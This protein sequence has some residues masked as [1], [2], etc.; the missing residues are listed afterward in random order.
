[1]ENQF[2]NILKELKKVQKFAQKNFIQIRQKL[3][4]ETAKKKFIVSSNGLGHYDPNY[5]AYELI[6][7]YK[8]GKA[9]NTQ[10]NKDCQIFGLD[11]NDRL[12]YILPKYLDTRFDHEEIHRIDYNGYVYFLYA[13]DG[14]FANYGGNY[15]AK[16]ENGRLIE[17]ASIENINIWLFQ[18]THLKNGKIICNLYHSLDSS[19]NRKYEFT[20]EDNKIKDLIEITNG[21]IMAVDENIETVDMQEAFNDWLDVI[22]ADINKL[23]IAWNFNLYELSH[24]ELVGTKSFDKKDE[25]WACDEI[26][27]TREKYPFFVLPE[28]S[29]EESLQNAILLIKNY[30]KNGKH[31][32]KFLET[33]AVACGFAD[34]DL[35]LIYTNPDKKLKP[36][37]EIATM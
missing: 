25:D 27:A 7:G 20:L 4:V 13:F 21:K 8:K 32:S 30:L 11:K 31:K 26:F 5:L 1:M 6:G 29:W 18:Y 10:P 19:Y 23:P 35:K 16:Y 36:K 17:W 37:K 12:L 24:M 15:R 3:E 28:K 33:H 34:G 2:K 9:Y 14:K 22:L